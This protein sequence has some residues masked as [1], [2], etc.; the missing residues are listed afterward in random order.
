MCGDLW[1]GVGQGGK[2]AQKF[3]AETGNIAAKL[4]I[5]LSYDGVRVVCKP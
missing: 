5:I 4:S 1:H 3:E 2:H